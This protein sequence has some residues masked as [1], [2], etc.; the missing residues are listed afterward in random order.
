MGSEGPLL[1]KYL[2]CKAAM[3][4]LLALGFSVLS[5]EWLSALVLLAAGAG[6]LIGAVLV[7]KRGRSS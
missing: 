4:T 2:A 7:G 5:D 3:L 1:A 6:Y